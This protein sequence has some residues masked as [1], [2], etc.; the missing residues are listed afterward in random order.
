M[1]SELGATYA[2]A[3][4]DIAAGDAAVERIKDVVASTMRSG[5]LGGIG[6]FG[7]LFELDMAKYRHPILVAGTDGIGTKL[8]IARQVNRFDTVGIDLVAMCVD[9]LICV[10]AEPLFLL[11]YIAVGAVDPLHIEAL[12]SGIAE[13]CRQARCALLG[14]ETAEHGGVMGV[15]DVDVAGFAVGVVEKGSQLGPNRVAAGDVLIGIASPGIRSNGYTLVRNVFFDRANRSLDAPAWDGSEAT[16]ADEL[17]R[18][19]V[20]YTPGVLDA[21]AN[22]GTGIH[23]A[24]HITGGGLSGNLVR[25]LPDGIRATVD[26]QDLVVPEIFN[27]IQR[28]GS[29]SD[30]EMERVFNLGLG[31]V[32]IVAPESSGDVLSA[33]NDSNLTASVIGSTAAGEKGVAY[34]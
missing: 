19:S 2:A 22:S 31:M 3:G 13:G 34:Q 6:G 28:L 20:I 17:L 7:G 18:P 25:A 29:V 11:D 24:A 26:R 12:V 32:L 16:L 33:L 1:T 21:L 4:V 14:G 30:V 15:G 5:V 8:E 23:A 27:E 9:D 10:G